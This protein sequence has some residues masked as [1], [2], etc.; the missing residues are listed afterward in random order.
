VTTPTAALPSIVTGAKFAVQMSYMFTRFAFLLALTLL[1][2]NC[3]SDV[4]C[5]S[6]KAT[7]TAISILRKQMIPNPRIM[8]PLDEQSDFKLLS[9]RTRE[10]SRN[11]RCAP[12]N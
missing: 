10:A 8:L 7:A 4:E 11:E 9:I 6:S 12:Q 2:S 3:S 1:I 5:S